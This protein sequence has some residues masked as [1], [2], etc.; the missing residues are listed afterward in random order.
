M[1]FPTYITDNFFDD[2]HKA[3]KLSSSLDYKKDPLGVWPGKRTE[4]LQDIDFGFFEHVTTR[5]M[6]LI[7]P[8]SIEHLQWSAK[9]C[10]QY[11]DYGQ[12]AREGW[13]HKDNNAQLS[14]VIYLSQHKGCGTSLY[15]PKHFTRSLDEKVNDIRTDYYINNKK[16][17]KKFFNALKQNNS[18][19]ERTL[20][21]ASRFNRFVAY[22]AHQWHSADGFFNKDIK[23]GRLTLVSFINNIGQPNSQLKFPLPEMK[24][25]I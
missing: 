3:V 23:G 19:F 5:I 1:L 16:F 14:V 9:T 24:R 6:R 2:P 7:Y 21:I 20:Q 18:K 17:D 11:I 22:D 12:E 8:Q 25:T 4:W 13:V 10:F 15:K